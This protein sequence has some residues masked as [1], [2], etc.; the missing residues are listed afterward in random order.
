MLARG[1][2][3]A[4]TR[5]PCRVAPPPLGLSLTHTPQSQVKL[6][7]LMRLMRIAKIVRKVP[8]LQV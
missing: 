7:R 4:H 1:A 8:Q 5:A 6:L 3:S 2:A